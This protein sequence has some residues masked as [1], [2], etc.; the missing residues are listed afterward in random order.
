[1][2][3]SVLIV[4]DEPQVG[5]VLRRYFEREQFETTMA[6]SVAE[7]LAELDRRIPDIAILDITLPDGTGF[8]ILRSIRRSHR[9]PVILLSARAEEVDR[10]VGLELGADDYVTKPFF[11][12]EVVARA[13][14]LLRR[15]GQDSPRARSTQA[16]L[17]SGQVFHINDTSHEVHLDGKHIPLTATEFRV[18]QI[19]AS[20]SGTVLSRAQII[21]LL[22]G[23]GQVYERTLDRHIN[24][25]RRKLEPNPGRPVHILTVYG[26]GYRMP[27]LST[28]E[29]N[30]D[31]NDSRRSDA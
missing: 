12:R 1:M 22:K 24:N 10:I 15:S 26:V 6:L 7:A 9:I 4:D 14:A 25:I 28:I 11:P 18:L 17:S 3:R 29:P 19:L 13:H 8:E 2:K 30:D 31:M 16:R 5:E 20:N 27:A 23:D 21:D